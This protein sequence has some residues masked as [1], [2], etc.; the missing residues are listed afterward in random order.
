MS[1]TDDAQRTGGAATRLMDELRLTLG[2]QRA[3]RH[4]AIIVLLLLLLF[5][6]DRL[7]ASCVYPRLQDIRE[8]SIKVALAIVRNKYA[9][10][11]ATVLPQ[12]EDLE[13]HIRSVTYNPEY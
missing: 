8:V 1:H 2:C 7:E 5:P 4:A 9:T 13:A 3:R 12:P 10:G 6:Q 11:R